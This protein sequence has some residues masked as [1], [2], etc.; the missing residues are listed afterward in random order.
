MLLLEFVLL[1]LAHI[2]RIGY[3]EEN[4]LAGVLVRLLSFQESYQLVKIFRFCKKIEG[5]VVN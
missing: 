2:Q 3:I 5:H 1:L 4:S